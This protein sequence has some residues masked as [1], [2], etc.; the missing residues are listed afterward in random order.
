MRLYK[1]LLASGTTTPRPPTPSPPRTSTPIKPPTSSHRPLLEKIHKLEYHT[2]DCYQCG[3]TKFGA[4]MTEVCGPLG[5]CLTPWDQGTFNPGGVDTF[6]TP[7][8]LGECNQFPLTKAG[9]FYPE[10]TVMRRENSQK[11]TL[12]S[13]TKLSL[14]FRGHCFSSR[15]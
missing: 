6:D 8:Y 13:S 14:T 3:M 10:G 4:I 2:S 5:C 9:G 7:D 11:L 12:A 1:P 15:D